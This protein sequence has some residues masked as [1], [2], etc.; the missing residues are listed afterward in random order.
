MCSTHANL[1]VVH[2]TKDEGL[3]RVAY[4]VALQAHK[5][6]SM[7]L[8]DLQAIWLWQ[9]AQTMQMF[10]DLVKVHQSQFANTRSKQHVSSMTANSL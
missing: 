7:L 10:A 3:I 6:I 9:H 5:A 4:S 1:S 8:T 2:M